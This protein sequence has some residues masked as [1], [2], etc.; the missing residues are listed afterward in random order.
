MSYFR[1][2]KS[3]S[4]GVGHRHQYIL[5]YLEVKSTKKMEDNHFII[6]SLFLTSERWPMFSF[7]LGQFT[8]IPHVAQQ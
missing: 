8:V 7:V 1:L 4:L 5:K 3:E 2:I 6:E